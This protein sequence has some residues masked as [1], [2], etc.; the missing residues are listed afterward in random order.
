[1]LDS[2]NLKKLPPLKSLKGFEAAA[3]LQSV[4][5]AAEELHLTHP[6]VS[7][8]IQTLEN[9]LSVKLFTRVGRAIRLSNEGKVYYEFVREALDILITGTD[10]VSNITVLPALQVQTYITL[11]I[12]WLAPL[13]HQFQV[14]HPNI[15]IQLNTCSVSWEFDKNIADIGIIYSLSE[16]DNDMHWVEYFESKVFPVCSPS[17]IKEH[18]RILSPD[19]LCQYP[20][21]NVYTE[22]NYWNWEQWFSVSNATLD[23]DISTLNVDTAAAALELAINGDGIALVNGPTADS[24]LKS[25]VL[26]KPVAQS[27][28]GFGKWGLICRKTALND[29]RVKMFLDWLVTKQLNQ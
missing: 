9:A 13:L 21:I 26:V 27:A 19:D 22:E 5:A 6:A 25:G 8:Q 10:K 1:M 23:N 4:R 20:L 18:K 2:I 15:K 29:P 17:L 14:L 12:R 11:S 3:R 24:Y 7:H 16:P 28:K